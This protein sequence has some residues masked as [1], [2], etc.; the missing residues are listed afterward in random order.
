MKLKLGIN[1]YKSIKKGCIE[2]QYQTFASESEQLCKHMAR[3]CKQNQQVERFFNCI[4]RKFHNQT[5][6]SKEED[7]IE[8]YVMLHFQKIKSPDA[9]TLLATWESL[10]AHLISL[11][12]S[13]ADLESVVC[14][15]RNKFDYKRRTIAPCEGLDV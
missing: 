14:W 7:C 13:S 5:F 6:Y 11:A 9:F 12:S 1:I 10:V 8:T 3:R 2:Q 4:W 15:F